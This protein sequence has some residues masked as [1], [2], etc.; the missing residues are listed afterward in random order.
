MQIDDDV[1]DD[2]ND[3]DRKERQ[4]DRE[5]RARREDE[6]VCG[7]LF[8]TLNYGR[9]VVCLFLSLSLSFFVKNLCFVWGRR[10]LLCSCRRVVVSKKRR[11]SRFPFLDFET[12]YDLLK[13][14]ERERERRVY[15]CILYYV[16]M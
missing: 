8:S 4:R 6:D 2:V 3:D 15:N 11:Y 5:R 14:R 12:L 16:C 10:L 7:D 9:E 13:K 1:N